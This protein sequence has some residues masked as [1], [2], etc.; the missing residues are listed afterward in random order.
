MV[1]DDLVRN[2]EEDMKLCEQAWQVIYFSLN[3]VLK[4]RL[5]VNDHVQNIEEDMILC[6]QAWQELYFSLNALKKILMVANDHKQNI[7]KVGCTLQSKCAIRNK[8]G[9]R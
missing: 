3:V 5:V 6:E 4:I 7:E 8:D 2:I 9:R 1:A